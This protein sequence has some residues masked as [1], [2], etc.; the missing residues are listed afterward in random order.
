M[1]INAPRNSWM[2]MNA[3]VGESAGRAALH[4]A[5]AGHPVVGSRLFMRKAGWR[6]ETVG[7]RMSKAP[8]QQ[9]EG[10]GRAAGALKRKRKRP[11]KQPAGQPGPSAVYASV[12][13][14]L[15]DPDDGH[16]EDR[17]DSI[18][19]PVPDPQQDEWLEAARPNEQSVDE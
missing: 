12:S 19:G 2:N 17:R 5:G 4:N 6:V 1:K 16:L 10:S 3:D 14:A 13:N 11:A 9:G 8:G 18:E 7:N 15:L